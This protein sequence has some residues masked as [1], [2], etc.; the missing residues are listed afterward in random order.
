MSNAP[1]PSSAGG[2]NTAPGGAKGE[3][4]TK[5]SPAKMLVP[6]LIT[7]GIIIGLVVAYGGIRTARMAVEQPGELHGVP[8]V[9]Q[10]IKQPTGLTFSRPKGWKIA[11]QQAPADAQT[12]WALGPEGSSDHAFFITKYPLKKQPEDDD[13]IRTI[14]QEAELSLRLTGAP[15]D[16]RARKNPPPVGEYEAWRYQYR[17]GDIQT[18]VA[19]V[20]EEK[21]LY[22]FACQSPVGK[23]EDSFRNGCQAIEDTIEIN[24]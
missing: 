11:A 8:V 2:E 7:I 22:Q 12:R 10:A 6:S 5:R 23:Q 9:K 15:P 21:A 13:Q 1:E 16:L 17:N 24:P 19:L 4:S 14:Q 20:L 18:N 3:K